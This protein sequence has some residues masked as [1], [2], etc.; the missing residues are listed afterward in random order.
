MLRFVRILIGAAAAVAIVVSSASP[1]GAH[2]NDESYL[3]MD[4]GDSSLS[5][6]VE[7]PYPDIRTVFDLRLSGSVADISAEVV[8]LRRSTWTSFASARAP[9]GPPT[10]LSSSCECSCRRSRC[11]TGSPPPPASRPI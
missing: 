11:L 10:A 2:R 8:V 1:A 7:M 6:R 3:Y 9:A 4:V 5:G